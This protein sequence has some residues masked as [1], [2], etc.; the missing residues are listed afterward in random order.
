[1]WDDFWLKAL[2]SFWHCSFCLHDP[3]H[4]QAYLDGWAPSSLLFLNVW[5]AFDYNE[6]C[7]A[8]CTCMWKLIP[9]F[10]PPNTNQLNQKSW[11]VV[12]INKMPCFTKLNRCRQG[13]QWTWIQNSAENISKLFLHK[14][15]VDNSIKI[16]WLRC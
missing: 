16:K 5:V 8:T 3:S 1:M 11:Q 12:C 6:Q 14:W 9:V 7:I 4:K 2:R 13:C 15:V 10:I